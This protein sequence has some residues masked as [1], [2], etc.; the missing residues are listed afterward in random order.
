MLTTTNGYPFDIQRVL[1]NPEGEPSPENMPLTNI[2]E[3]P[4]ITKEHD[5]RRG[6]KDKPSYR[7]EFQVVLEHWYLS[8]SEG[9]TSRDIMTYL[10]AARQI[11]FVDGIT[12]GRK[13][14]IVEE[15]EES[16][17]YRPLARVVGIGHVLR[18]E[19]LEDF[20]NL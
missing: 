17:V 14:A 1:R 2:F 8:D 16:R 6:A 4:S 3:F 10:K 13:A 20:N 5:P 15:V 7:K 18:I 9:E 11:L 19:Y 12:L